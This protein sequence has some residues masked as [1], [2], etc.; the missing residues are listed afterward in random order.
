MQPNCLSDSQIASKILFALHLSGIW[1]GGGEGMCCTFRELWN[2]LPFSLFFHS[3]RN[4]FCHLSCLQT[5]WM[6]SRNVSLTICAVI[7]PHSNGYCVLLSLSLMTGF[8]LHLCVQP[9]RTTI[10][11]HSLWRRH[12][13]WS[14][15][16]IKKKNPLEQGYQTISSWVT[17][18]LWL[19]SKGCKNV[20]TCSHIT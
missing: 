20:F 3:L 12:V 11:T 10:N 13:V 15:V 19:C 6:H 18:A 2:S 14:Y 1:G 4:D 7:P 8:S 5:P 16:K 9:F 17:S